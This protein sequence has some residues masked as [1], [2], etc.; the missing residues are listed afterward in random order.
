[1]SEP[2]YTNIAEIKRANARAGKFWFSKDT[3]RAFKPR[4]ETRIYDG[5][6]SE[7]FPEGVRYWVESTTNYD[8]SGRE[9]KLAH[10]DVATGD[11]G[12]VHGP[13]YTRVCFDTAAQAQAY[14]EGLLNR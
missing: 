3:V 8:D 12:Y 7:D 14:L 4:V 11:I 1:M 9:Y 5:G 6:T 10:F 2:R 13:E